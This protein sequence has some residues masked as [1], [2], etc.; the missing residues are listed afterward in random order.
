M[1][2]IRLKKATRHKRSKTKRYLLAAM[3]SSTVSLCLLLFSHLTILFVHLPILLCNCLFCLCN[4]PICL[5]TCLYVLSLR[6]S[7]VFPELL[8]EIAGAS[9]LLFILRETVKT[10]TVITNT[11]ASSKTMLLIY[12]L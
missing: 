2:L 5:R 4:C 12:P 7:S 1:Y 6:Y 11:I 3:P 9:C 10:I 8:S